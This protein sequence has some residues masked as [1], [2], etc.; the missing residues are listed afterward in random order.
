MEVQAQRCGAR[1]VSNQHYYS[2]E[3]PV[4]WPYPT[5]E[6]GLLLMSNGSTEWGGGLIE[7]TLAM[8][9]QKHSEIRR[10]PAEL[11]LRECINWLSNHA[12]KDITIGVA[13]EDPT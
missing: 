8:Y 2:S 7:V 3:D 9:T 6:S 10:A 12:R 13:Q 4:R 5:E 11:L 1:H